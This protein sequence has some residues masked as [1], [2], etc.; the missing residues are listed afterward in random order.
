MKYKVDGS[1][2]QFKSRRKDLRLSSVTGGVSG[3]LS[4]ITT[5]TLEAVGNPW[6]FRMNLA[7]AASR[8]LVGIG[9][10]VLDQITKEDMENLEK[11]LDVIHQ[12]EYRRNEIDKFF[13]AKL[14]EHEETLC[15]LQEKMK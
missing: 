4:I 2:V 11:E 14:E 15:E 3:A 9:G 13:H 8:F 1:I 5:L 12:L 6:L 7:F 10:Y